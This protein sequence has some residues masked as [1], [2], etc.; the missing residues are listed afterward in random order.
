[1]KFLRS[2]DTANILRNK[3]QLS[4]PIY[5]KLDLT[6]EEKT[7]ESMLLKECRSLIDKEVDHK[8]IKL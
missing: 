3:V 7:Q 4:P 6:L 1:M 8:Q 5:I 2:A